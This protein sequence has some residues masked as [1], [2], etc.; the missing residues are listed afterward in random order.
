M[1]LA[2][3]FGNQ[4]V[5]Q[6]DI[7][8]PVWGWTKPLAK[9]I[10]KVGPHQ[11]QSISGTDGKFLVR[12]PPMPAGGPY[13]LE[14]SSPDT[15]EKALSHDIWIGEV[16][17]ASGQSN[18][19]FSFAQLHL[20]IPSQ[21]PPTNPAIRMANV[22]RLAYAGQQSDA[23]LTWQTC[24]PT[25]TPNFSAVGY[26]FAAELQ[27]ALGV[28]VGIINSSWG[29]TIIEAW[30]S[31]ETLVQNPQ[32]NSWV[33]RYEANCHSPEFWDPQAALHRQNALPADPGNDGLKQGWANLAFDD[34]SWKDMELPG[35]WTAR[36]HRH[37]GIFWFRRVVDVPRA[38][39]GKDLL[40][41]L[42]AADKHDITYFNGQQVGATGTGF[43]E[44][45]WNIVR[46]YRIPG[47]LVKEGKNI[48]ASRVYSFA[49]DGGLIGPAHI[50]TLSLPDSSDKP[51]P[52]PGSWK[53][54]VE[55]NFGLVV[56]P[57]ANPGPGVPNSPYIL[58]DN[59]IAPLLPYALRGAIWYQGESN[60]S[61]AHKYHRL[62]LDLIRDWRHAWGQGDFP[63]LFTQLANYNA[64]VPWPLL[65]EAQLQTLAEPHTGMAVTID[66]G[67]AADI[68]PKNKL[69]V[70]RRLAAWAL[71]QTY[72]QHL[73]YSGPL[74]AG[75]TIEGAR[76]RIHFNHVTGGLQAKGGP[77][78]RF[79]IAGEDRQFI[80]ADA[81]I[82]G[83]TILVSSHKVTY[84]IAVRYA[85]E[86]NPE[87]CNLYNAAN[88]PASPFRT[89][90]W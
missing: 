26:F 71:S 52:L 84:P 53:Y 17:I 89:D 73:A 43:E 3:L 41:S 14:V 1:K 57:R 87:G 86:N 79:L 58:Y 45:H 65:R 29:G 63:F 2:N 21:L 32:V 85:W 13:D 42:G 90:T 61:E 10:V 59:M 82:D 78:A 88:L 9:V 8:V 80:P 72:H 31:R 39:A 33:A 18:M 74:Y 48:I 35:A 27:K 6:R 56:P 44:F 40:L 22:A 23:P 37:S 46:T 20:D 60:A 67:D 19:E 34:S 49:Y 55:H 4:A 12:L 62:M 47:H 83:N 70:G 54:A 81:T 76:I 15:P 25:T 7:S 75:M 30:I 66:I 69:D 24:G 77:L 50:M 11:A 28:T 38:W 51:I 68:H 36:G 64:T 16:W 5:L